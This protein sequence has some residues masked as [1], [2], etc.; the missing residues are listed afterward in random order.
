MIDRLFNIEADSYTHKEIGGTNN[1]RIERLDVIS[2]FSRLLVSISANVDPKEATT[3]APSYSTIARPY[4]A[5]ISEGL[6]VI[7]SC[8]RSI[9]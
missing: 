3:T 5:R 6:S 2:V 8:F 7:R 4:N 1:G 9:S